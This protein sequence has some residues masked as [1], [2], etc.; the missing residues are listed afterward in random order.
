MDANY[1]ASPDK[2]TEH[3]LGSGIYEFKLTQSNSRARLYIEQGDDCVA[4]YSD[5]I[6]LLITKL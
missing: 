1:R 5:D 6:Q 2:T 4:V 3:F